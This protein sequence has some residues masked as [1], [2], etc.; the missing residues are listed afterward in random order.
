MNSEAFTLP[1]LNRDLRSTDREYSVCSLT[2]SRKFHTRKHEVKQEVE[3]VIAVFKASGEV[4]TRESIR[5]IC[6]QN[7][8][9]SPMHYCTD[10]MYKVAQCESKAREQEGIYPNRGNKV[11]GGCKPK[12]RSLFILG[13]NQQFACRSRNKTANY[14]GS[15]QVDLARLDQLTWSR[16]SQ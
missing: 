5:S 2:E 13:D 12:D 8:V 9:C 10:H 6:S 1:S 7:V 14:T 15:A 3:S 4:C 11:W 16:K